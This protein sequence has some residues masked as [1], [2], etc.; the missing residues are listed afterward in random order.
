M[1]LYLAGPMRNKPLYNFPAFDRVCWWL[2]DRGHTP[3]SPHELDRLT[4]INEYVLT[5]SDITP[6]MVRNFFHRDLGMILTE[7]EGVVV[8][9]GWEQSAGAKA[10]VALALVLG[11]PIFDELMCH[12]DVTL[13]A[14]GRPR[15]TTTEETDDVRL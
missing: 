9:R 1:K 7:A 15:E 14:A 8:L 10:E 4:G 11:L 5:D 6:A 12:L 2:R 13:T 3:I